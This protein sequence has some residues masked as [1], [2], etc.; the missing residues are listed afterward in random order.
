MAWL[1][2]L[3]AGLC[4]IGWAVGLKLSDGFTRLGASVLTVLA[5]AVSIVLLGL[6]MRELPLGTA[7][8]AWTGIGA[9]GTVLLGILLFDESASAGR[10]FCVSLIVAGI[11]GLKWLTPEG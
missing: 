7:Y 1:L 11:V 9:V 5:M 3:F 2:L 6:A 4:E 8:A 10:L